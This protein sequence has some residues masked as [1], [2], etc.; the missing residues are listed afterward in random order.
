MFPPSMPDRTRVRAA[1]VRRGME[2]VHGVGVASQ[3]DVNLC[4]V[5]GGDSV[6]I[7]QTLPYLLE[8]E[9]SEAEAFLLKAFDDVTNES[10]L[11]SIRFDGDEGALS[12][13]S[14]D[15]SVLMQNK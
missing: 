1:G 7:P 10:S 6:Q 15:T 5:W 3:T 12:L 8:L 11:N 14:H 2:S 13:G 9:S 4:R